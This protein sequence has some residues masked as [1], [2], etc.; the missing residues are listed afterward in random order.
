V[1][2][3][4]DFLRLLKDDFNFPGVFTEPSG[5]G[6]RGWA[7]FDFSEI[8]YSPFRFRDHRLS[9]GHNIAIAQDYALFLEELGYEL[10]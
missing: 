4:H 3:A 6:L 10:W 5:H 8:N 7:R 2:K 9:H 1:G